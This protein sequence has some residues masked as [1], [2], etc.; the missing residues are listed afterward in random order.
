MTMPLPPPSLSAD[1]PPQAVLDSLEEGVITTFQ[2][3][4]RWVRRDGVPVRVR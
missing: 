3:G 2:N 4:Q 1:L